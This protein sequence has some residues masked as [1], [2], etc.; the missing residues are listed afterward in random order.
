MTFN[1]PD[2]LRGNPNY[3]TDKIYRV[4]CQTAVVANEL[5]RRGFDVQALGNTKGSLL[6]KLS[7]N[8]NHIWRDMDGNIPE[9]MLIGAKREP[10]FKS[11]PDL[12]MWKLEKPSAIENNSFSNSNP[13]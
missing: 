6:E 7:R 8:T 3:A 2:I 9:Q 10:L 1:E 4:N 13:L 12:D 11:R 5:R